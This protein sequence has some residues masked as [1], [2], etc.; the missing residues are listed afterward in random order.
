MLENK[1]NKSKLF[2]KISKLYLVLIIILLL[3]SF[4][5]LSSKLIPFRGDKAAET[6][7][8]CKFIWENVGEALDDQSREYIENAKSP[9]KNP[10]LISQS[11]Q[12]FCEISP[13]IFYEPCNN[14]FEKLFFLTEDFIMGLP[15]NELCK[16]NDLC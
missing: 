11:F 3:T 2:F 12:Y 10:I 4:D 14:M 13:D 16:K 6:C 7:V 1:M 5:K 15:V 9:R 8:A